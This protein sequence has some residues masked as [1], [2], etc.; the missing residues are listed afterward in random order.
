MNIEPRV[1]RKVAVR[2]DLRLGK[3]HM[4]IQNV[5]GWTN[6]HLHQFDAGG[7]VRYSHPHPRY[8]MDNDFQD[9]CK[10]KLSDLASKP[11]DRFIYEYD[12]GDS[13]EYMIELV[14]IE[15]PQKNIKYPVCLAGEPA[16]PPEDCGG[17]LS[18]PE[19]LMTLKGPDNK[20]RQE[21]LDWLDGKIDPEAFD[22]EAI[23]QRLRK[24]K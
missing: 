18:Y 17:P 4:I 21:L 24:W 14:A 23:E 5:M 12:F 8:D 15:E 11:K 10:V 22:M 7:G 6:S 9:E 20:K 19:L 13:W 16:C 1:W 3:L 2:A